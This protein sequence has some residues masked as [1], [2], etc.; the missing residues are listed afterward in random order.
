MHLP[1]E[2]NFTSSFSFS[3][4]FTSQLSHFPFH[5]RMNIDFFFSFYNPRRLGGGEGGKNSYLKKSPKSGV[6][7]IAYPGWRR[8]GARARHVVRSESRKHAEWRAERR[9]A[10]EGASGDDSAR[11]TGPFEPSMSSAAGWERTSLLRRPH[12]ALSLSP[13][14]CLSLSCA[15]APS[16]A[17][18]LLRARAP[19]SLPLFVCE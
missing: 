14:R 12:R 10:G 11:V 15:R 5:L 13:S 3:F 2:L 9:P 6:G 17:R 16:L 19:S 1:L 18:S 7:M 8:A 4:R